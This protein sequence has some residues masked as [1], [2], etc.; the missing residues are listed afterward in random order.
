[1]P[2]KGMGCALR[3]AYAAGQIA[4]VTQVS[5]HDLRHTGITH[6]VRLRIKKEWR[7]IMV[8]HQTEM[9]DRLNNQY[10]YDREKRVTFGRW[11]DELL[12]LLNEVNPQSPEQDDREP[13][14]IL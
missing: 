8:K 9:L 14:T 13:V 7:E 3:R 5:P 10:E 4:G 11:E 12:R 6:F 1:M 2:E